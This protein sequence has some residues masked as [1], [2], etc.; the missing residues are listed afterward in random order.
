VKLTPFIGSAEGKPG[1]WTWSS[2][3]EMNFRRGVDQDLYWNWEATLA[4]T[5]RARSRD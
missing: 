2:E 4:N 5:T 1:K 3:G